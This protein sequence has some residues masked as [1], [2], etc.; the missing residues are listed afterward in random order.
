MLIAER[1]LKL[2]RQGGAIDVPIRIFKPEM[3]EGAWVCR[4][5]ID[6]PDRRHTMAAS[7]VD[8]VQAMIVAIELI[9]ATIYSSTYH[10]ADRLVF[11]RPGGGY[12]FPVP[13]NL[14]DMLIGD[15]AKFF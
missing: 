3:A 9:G 11:E 13:A 1:T 5:E 12:G 6:W 14:R 15:D 10:D 4:Y 8:A 7:G 2:H